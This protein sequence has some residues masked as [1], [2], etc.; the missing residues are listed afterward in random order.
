M[1]ALS[2]KTLELAPAAGGNVTA[3][4]E[5][6]RARLF[7]GNYA[8]YLER[9]NREINNEINDNANN[10][11][12][13]RDDINANTITVNQTDSAANGNAANSAAEQRIQNKRRQSE[14]R[15]L[16]RQ[17]EEL[18]AAIEE[19]ERE[20]NR[21]ETELSD[22]KVYSNG[23]KAK[24]VKQKLDECAAALAAKT[25]EWEALAAQIEKADGVSPG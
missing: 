21:L 14:I 18:L 22:P 8:Y 1:E 24:A 4:S 10:D 17:E 11:E 13:K 23:E 15:R 2:T 19:Q 3:G 5:P 20:K 9:I 25:A 7:Y 6:S 16:Q 12:I